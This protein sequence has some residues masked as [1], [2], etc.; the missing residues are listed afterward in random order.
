MQQRPPDLPHR[1]V[2]GQRRALSP[3]LIGC[4]RDTDGEVV[5]EAGHVVMGDCNAFRDTGGAG[6]VDDVGD[7]LRGRWCSDHGDRLR[8][9]RSGDVRHGNPIVGEPRAVRCG[10][11]HQDWCGIGDDERDT[12]VGHRWIDGQIRRT[13][14]EHREDRHDSI[15]RS[16]QQQRDRTP[17]LR[18]LGNQRLRQTIR[19][20]V[21]FAV[22]HLPTVEGQR[23]SVGCARHL[24][25]ESLRDR[26]RLSG[27][28]E[29]SGVAPL[30][31]QIRL[32]VVEQVERQKSAR[33][34]THQASPASADIAESNRVNRAMTLSM[35]AA[36][37]TA[38][39]NSTRR[40]S[41]VPG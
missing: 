33:R 24:L 10:S 30:A 13:G 11:D 28:A 4:H 9:D 37:K 34:L 2:E 27:G 16:R 1:E 20:V 22:G 23:D 12:R 31:E 18:A 3:H 8:S 32:V 6:G 39:S 21:E 25:G 35:R 14:F 26:R 40:C 38:V 5:E 7:V 19:G 29:H 15:R 41:R 36:V 17:G